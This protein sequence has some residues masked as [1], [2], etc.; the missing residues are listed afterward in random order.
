VAQADWP[1]SDI[2]SHPSKELG[3]LL[4]WLCYTDSTINI[5]IHYYYYYYYYNYVLPTGQTTEYRRN[6]FVN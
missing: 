2:G 3:E 4:Q 1:G 5:V 6:S